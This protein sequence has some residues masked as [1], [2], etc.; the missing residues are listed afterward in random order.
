[1][2]RYNISRKAWQTA[3]NILLYY[4]DN[5]REYAGLLDM[6]LTAGY[7]EEGNSNGEGS[8]VSDPTARAA[9]RLASNKRAA[10]L[11]LEIEAVDVAVAELNAAEHEVIRRR[12]WTRRQNHRP[13]QYD[14]LQD[15]P[16]S[17]RQMHRIVARTIFRIAQLVGE[18]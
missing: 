12:F 3:T 7:E 9:I 6:V 5:K 1:M 8:D 11:K 13:R 2:G 14:Y 4:Q 15:L 18:I 17:Q 16:F 10:R